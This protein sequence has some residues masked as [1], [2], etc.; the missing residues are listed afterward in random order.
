MKQEN[1]G[2]LVLYTGG[3]I[4]SMP[5][6]PNDPESPQR[7][8][9]WATFLKHTPQIDPD[10]VGKRADHIGFRV[11]CWSLEPPLDSC[12]V[13]PEDWAAMAEVIYKNH[14]DY[15]GFVILHGTDTMV[16]TASALS[17]MLENLKKPVILTG[18]QRSHTF[19]S[20]NDGLQNMMTA[21][22]FANAKSANIEVVPEVCIYFGGKLL[23]GNRCRKMDAE[24]FTA[25][26][27]PNYP[28]LGEAGGVLRVD[29]E[30]ILPVPTQA[31][32]L[33]RRLD[34]SVIGLD[35]FPG[36]QDS[37]LVESI[38]GIKDIKAMVVRGFGTG[39]I[40]T[41]PEFLSI[42]EEA[43]LNRNI[44]IINVSQCLK[45]GVALGMY[46]TSAQLLEIGML[47]G[48]DLTPESALC[49]LMV[50]LGDEDLSTRDIR[51][52]AQQSI[53]GE[54]SKS[55]HVQAMRLDADCLISNEAPRWRL[56]PA[57]PMGGAFRPADMFN[58][59]LRLYEA[60]V[61]TDDDTPL[62][63]EIYLNVASDDVL[64][65]DSPN[66]AGSFKRRNS[67]EPFIVSFDIT[68]A[69]RMLIKPGERI[70]ATVHLAN[71][72][73]S[74]SWSKSEIAVFVPSNS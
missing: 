7:V 67:D 70:S 48:F 9:D 6:D 11:D 73:G 25:Y 58:A 46:E 35:L 53:A 47:T 72:N 23:R 5:A 55:L 45:G 34:R 12:N 28:A 26:F 68:S 71:G 38:L 14:D 42:F 30:H 37:G 21:L 54:M 61:K 19:M 20:R 16:Y 36:I 10:Q 69:A 44:H 29:R 40:P 22:M 51:E 62:E 65:K 13:A 49:K 50:L 39:N 59:V 15:E 31:L 56:S 64:K 32:Q 27:S 33:R 66:F 24:G 43:T 18:A 17:F 63:I 1:K 2:V 52:R 41:K 3:T 74:L 57:S 60:E 8:V 4:G